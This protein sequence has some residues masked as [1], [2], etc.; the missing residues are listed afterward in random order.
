[1][2]AVKKRVGKLGRSLLNIKGCLM[3]EDFK[4]KKTASKNKLLPFIEN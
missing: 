4:F 3:S 2:K 1:M